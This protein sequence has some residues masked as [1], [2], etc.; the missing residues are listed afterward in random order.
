MTESVGLKVRPS[1]AGGPKIFLWEILGR[2]QHSG[3]RVQKKRIRIRIRIRD[4]RKP[5]PEVASHLRPS[6]KGRVILSG[7]VTRKRGG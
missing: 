1:L 6:R 7:R 2:G 5:L 4:K 3:L